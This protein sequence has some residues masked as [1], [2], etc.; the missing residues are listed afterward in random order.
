[1]KTM[2]KCFT[3]ALFCVSTTICAHDLPQIDRHT[4]QLGTAIDYELPSK[5]PQILSNVFKWTV[6]ADCKLIETEQA[7]ELTFKVLRKKISFNEIILSRGEKITAFL[8]KTKI[9]KI[10]PKTIFSMQYCRLFTCE[11]EWY[12]NIENTI[13]DGTDL[14]K[15]SVTNMFIDL[16]HDLKKL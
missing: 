8:G 1:M 16:G 3:A 6:T 4:L 15:M 5:Q 9:P 7:H 10:R 13:G 2:L 14:W 11:S 12:E